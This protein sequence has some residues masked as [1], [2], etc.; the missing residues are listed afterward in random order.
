[1][2]DDPTEI[3]YNINEVWVKVPDQSPVIDDAV[4]ILYPAY[5]LLNTDNTYIDLLTLTQ[6]TVD[7]N[8]V[9]TNN[10]TSLS[11]FSSIFN[12]D[13]NNYL[14][15][16]LNSNIKYKIYQFDES[17]TLISTSNEFNSS[18]SYR[19]N[20]NTKSARIYFYDLVNTEDI[21]YIEHISLSIDN[22]T[23]TDTDKMVKVD[24]NGVLY[25]NLEDYIRYNEYEKDKYIKYIGAIETESNEHN[26]NLEIVNNDAD[27]Y[28]YDQYYNEF[29]P[30]KDS[31]YFTK[32]K[33]DTSPS[34][35]KFIKVPIDDELSKYKNDPNYIL[36]YDEITKSDEG[37]TWDGGL[38]HDDLK[39]KLLDHEFNAV[40]SK[41]ISVETVT[42]LT[43]QSF[44]VAYFYNMLFDNLYNEDGLTVDIPYLK[45]GHTF[46]FMDIIC[47]LFALMYLYHGLEDNIMYSPTQILYVK[48]YNFDEALNQISDT[49]LSYNASDANLNINNLDAK[50]KQKLINYFDINKE[51]NKRNYN[52]QKQFDGYTI[53]EFNLEA[54]IDEL[55]KWLQEY[56]QMSLD[57][58]IV[59]DTL[60][61]FSQIITLRQFF[62]LNNSYYQ[63][64]IFNKTNIIPFNYNQEISYAY[65]YYLLDKKVFY[66]FDGLKHYYACIY[67]NTSLNKAALIIDN[68]DDVIYKLYLNAYITFSDGNAHSLYKRYTT[69]SDKSIYNDFG[70]F[71]CYDSDT[72]SYYILFDNTYFIINKNNDIIFSADNF[73]IKNKNDEYELINESHEIYG[74]NFTPAA[75]Y[76][77]NRRYRLSLGLYWI[78]N[79]DGSWKLDN[80][81]VYFKVKKGN[82]NEY[83]FVNYFELSEHSNVTINEDDYYI[84]HDDGHFVKFTETD[85]YRFNSKDDIKSIY[86]YIKENSVYIRVSEN[87]N[88]NYT[89]TEL[90]GSVYYYKDATEY[91]SENNWNY[92]DKIYVKVSDNTYIPEDELL[93]PSNLYFYKDGNYELV[94]NNIATYTYSGP[95]TY[96]DNT[97]LNNI[98]NGLM[99]TLILSN[100]GKYNKYG[101]RINDVYGYA[102]SSGIVT[103]SNEIWNFDTRT[104]LLNSNNDYITV[105]KDI[106]DTSNYLNTKS[107]IV[108]LQKE[109]TYSSNIDE[110]SSEKYNP[111]IT[112]KV[113]DENDWFYPK[114]GEASSDIGLHGENIWYYRD[115][116]NP[117]Q[118]TEEDQIESKVGSGFFIE[119]SSYLGSTQLE[120]GN[121]Y[122]M[123]FDLET[124]FS[125][126]IQI[127]NTADNSVSSI[128]DRL[129]KVTKGEK[130]HISQIFIANEIANPEIRLLIYNFDKYPINIGDY[131]VISNMRFVK[132]TAHEDKNNPGYYNSNHYIAQDV[133]SYDMLQE[134]YRTNEAIY[135]WLCTEMAKESDLRKYNIL[136][137]IYDSL[138][139]SKYNKEA[140]KIGENKY[141][142]T[143]TDFL[144]NRD[145]VLYSKLVRFKSID[146]DTMHKEI[147]D[148]IIEVTYAIDDCVDTYSYGFIYSYFPA[149]S[150]TYI[151]QYITKIINW[152]KSWKVHLLG[153]NTVYKLGDEYENSVK[154]LETK[155]PRVKIDHY[156]K[157]VHIYDTVKINPIDEIN[158]SGE[159]YVDLYPDMVEYSHIPKDECI[160]K[161]RVRIISRIADK[162]EFKDNENNMH[163]TFNDNGTKVSVSNDNILNISSGEDGFSTNNDNELILTTEKTIDQYY[164]EQ[165]IDEINLLSGDY[166]DRRNVDNE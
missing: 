27:V 112:D 113:W 94:Y 143:Y 37:D 158:S 10:D 97:E 132:A 41:Y 165:I 68:T 66:D 111:E 86:D 67:D 147:A 152:F 100:N 156:K 64:D 78:Q 124:N 17:S 36:S 11:Y 131:I 71:Y 70:S 51:I 83:E 42:D 90:D 122:Y 12:I 99:Y 163:I 89:D 159:K 31:H 77:Y 125:G 136:K 149:V 106:D 16:M 49:I 38:D 59:D 162:I 87:D 19:L 39:N 127:Y 98:T 65:D 154:A 14:N 34:T 22:K 2:F 69:N 103:L 134:L 121:K 85:Y 56:T 79:E 123:A 104:Y 84:R 57:D 155:E 119:S 129:Y 7:N 166:L 26:N 40:K 3:T 92:I 102:G 58:F 120:S 4:S 18:Y 13:N 48:G 24:F 141:A 96:I 29:I 81:Y 109:V 25:M 60:I 1:L 164:A 45:I 6:G 151:Q 23:Y 142:K 9:S 63:K 126:E 150:A 80:N 135:K 82:N 52:Y 116:N 146:P 95:Y 44:Q 130:I 21:K 5:A 50:E 137:K 62:T 108:I 91:L 110:L 138:M 76:S 75:N 105:L 133:P 140:F 32:I 55:D 153:I 115:P 148:E 35:L 53:K 107:F 144:E 145:A 128:N 160:P 33:A 30:L 8:G 157:N 46:R 74:N 73:Y 54:D 117:N 139:V 93:S 43:E 72:N 61:N 114:D 28:I 88:Y 47:Y 118:E 15:I 161:D 101:D 20:N